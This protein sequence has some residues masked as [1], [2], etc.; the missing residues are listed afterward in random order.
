[1][2]YVREVFDHFGDKTIL[3]IGAGKMGELT[4]K[5]LKELRPGKHSRN[6]PELR[7]RPAQWPRGAAASRSPGTASTRR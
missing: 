5:H 4:L 7:R 2:D 1:M 6:Q 3:V